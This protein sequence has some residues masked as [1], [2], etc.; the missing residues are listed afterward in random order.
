MTARCGLSL[1]EEQGGLLEEALGSLAYKRVFSLVSRIH[2][3]RKEAVGAGFVM[4]LTAQE[5]A[6]C[7]EALG[8][9]PYARVH[10]LIASLRRQLIE[11]L[12]VEGGTLR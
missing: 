7:L 9:L 12:D 10:A 6:T 5:L 3:A 11:D 8:E 2:V 4:E 1:L